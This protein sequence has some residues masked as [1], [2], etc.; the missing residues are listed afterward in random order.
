MLR[1]IFAQIVFVTTCLIVPYSD[2]QAFSIHSRE[3]PPLSDF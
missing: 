1:I 3:L 2:E